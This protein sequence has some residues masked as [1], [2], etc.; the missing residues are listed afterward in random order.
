M[1][2]YFDLHT[3]TVASG[4]GFSTL[5]ENA[6]EAA[7]KGLKALGMSD[8]GPAMPG[9]AGAIYFGNFKA[10]RPNILGVDIYTGTEANIMDFNGRLDL[11]ES[12]LKKMDYVIASLHI[13]CIAPGTPARNTDALIRAM[14][15]PQV[16]IIGHPDDD[17]YPLEYERLIA[18][19]ARRK[20]ALEVNNSSFCAR[21]G[22][23][24]AEKN[25]ARWL[26]VAKEYRLPVIL[27]SDAH[28]WYDVGQ[29]EK[30][31]EMIRRAEYPPELVLNYSSEGLDYVLNREKE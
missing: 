5:K 13:P 26:A 12:I 23:R 4:H 21:S 29:L 3:H 8:H 6:E 7:K 15:N 14:E 9:S 18:A 25:T 24:N 30:A 16:K 2:I 10:V 17:R 27:G 19:A 11:D 1:K 22:R 31:E 20:V 28:I